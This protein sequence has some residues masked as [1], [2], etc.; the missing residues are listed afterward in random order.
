MS[1]L[2]QHKSQFAI[3]IAI[4]PQARG[5]YIHSMAYCIIDTI[6][7]REIDVFNVATGENLWILSSNTFF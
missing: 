7:K 2:K 6:L 4:L 5:V 3:K 1:R